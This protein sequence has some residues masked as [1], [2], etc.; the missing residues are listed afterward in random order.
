MLYHVS[1]DDLP[2]LRADQL[3]SGSGGS[4][5]LLHPGAPSRQCGPRPNPEI[6][7]MLLLLLVPMLAATSNVSPIDTLMADGHWKRASY[8]CRS[9]IQNEPE[10]RPRRLPDG[11]RQ[12]CLRQSR[13]SRPGS[14][15]PLSAWIRNTPPRNARPATSTA[16]RRRR[17]RSCGKWA[18]PTGAKPHWKRRSV[19]DPK[20]P[21]SDGKASVMYLVQAPRHR[22]R[23]YETSA[24][25]GRRADENGSRPGLLDSG[26]NRRQRKAES[27]RSFIKRPSKPTPPITPPA[28]LSPAITLVPGT[29]SR[30]RNII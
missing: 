17:P 2:H 6:R 15:K 16:T 5:G 11:P 24:R 18:W 29:T 7:V 23:R 28:S 9:R 13:R 3:H 25:P 10:R 12:A 19:L 21:A 14:L 20:D 26:P 27:R 8:R 4:N 22:R 1:P 30:R